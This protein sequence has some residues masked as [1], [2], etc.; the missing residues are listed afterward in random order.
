MGITIQASKLSWFY[1]LACHTTARISAVP[2]SKEELVWVI[3]YQGKSEIPASGFLET[4]A[5][6]KILTTADPQ[7]RKR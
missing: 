4:G 7:K 2:V 3:C 6:A 5:N 1:S